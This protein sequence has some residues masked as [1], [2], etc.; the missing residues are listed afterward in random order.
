[1]AKEYICSDTRLD[2]FS[3]YANMPYE[4][5]VKEAT[6]LYSAHSVYGDFCT[7]SDIS[8]LDSHVFEILDTYLDILCDALLCRCICDTDEKQ[9]NDLR[10]PMAARR[11]LASRG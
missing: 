5:L 7:D 3:L 8:I 10:P 11:A 6:A 1:M 4:Q 2:V 9:G